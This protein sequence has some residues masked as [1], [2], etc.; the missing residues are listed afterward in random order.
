MGKVIPGCWCFA[1]FFCES[2]S[3]KCPDLPLAYNFYNLHSNNNSRLAYS[4]NDL[5]CFF[6]KVFHS[7][8]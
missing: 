2:N 4:D 8:H 1:A 6:E 7:V 5:V 3:V